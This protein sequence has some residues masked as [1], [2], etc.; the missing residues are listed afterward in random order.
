M[1]QSDASADYSQHDPIWELPPVEWNTGIPLANGDIG[2]LVWG[3]GNPLKIT[4]DKYD[5][6]ETREAKL[7]D[8]TYAQLSEWVENGERE[9]AEQ[10]MRTN[11]IY[12]DAPYPTRLPLPRLELSFDK[13]FAWKSGR[14]D[15]RHAETRIAGAVGSEALQVRA[16]VDAE[17]NVILIELK[18]TPGKTATLRARMDHLNDNARETLKKW[19]YPEPETA[20]SD[21]EGSLVQRTPSGYAYAV[22]WYREDKGDRTTYR[23]AV[24]SADDGEN[25]L[26]KCGATLQAYEQRE[27]NTHRAWWSDYWNRSGIAIPDARM[28]A[29]YAIEMYKLG[30][31]SRPG[32]WPITLQALWTQ[33]G[34]MP[35]WSGDYHLDMNVQQSYWPIYTANRLELG[36]PLYRVFSDCIPRWREQAQAFF[37]FDGIWPGCAI[38]PKGERVFGYSGVELWPGN[39]AWL[40]HHYWLHYLYSQDENF[41]RDQALP[42]MRLSFL[43]YANLLEKGDDGKLH[44]PMSYS[45]EYHE[46]N[47]EGYAKDPNGDL[48]LIRFLAGAILESNDILGAR[49]EV[50]GRAE[51]VQRDLVDYK[52]ERKRLWVSADQPLAQSHRHHSHLMALHPLGLISPETHGALIEGSLREI[53]LRGTGLWTGWAY[54]W[55]SLIASRAGYAP[56]AW[57]ML[58]EYTNAFITPNTFHVNGDYRRFG[59]SQFD[60]QPMTLEAGFGAAA[61]IQEMLLQSQGGVIR[62]FPNMPPH[63][64]DAYVYKL[65]AEGAFVIIAELKAGRTQFALILSEAG[66]PCTIRNPFGGATTLQQLDTNRN[67]VVGEPRL[68]EGD[69]LRFDTERGGAYV[70]YPEGPFP[71]I[72]FDGPVPIQHSER[73][74]HFFGIKKLPRF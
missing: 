15:L 49:D 30:C 72:G 25:P 38:G 61:A 21:W 60:Y 19:G 36:E 18:G 66:R 73:D 2:A 55:M 46:G 59:T 1:S 37:G 43:T 31:S 52:Q 8:V 7:D 44:L 40:A 20:A 13:P 26:L 27:R 10:A 24:E 45:P 68:L 47:F 33:D 22:S 53:S 41:L 5:A 17:S 4:L 42:M 71:E 6:W 64:H 12:G 9:K 67:D 3:D 11:R 56:M 57:R 54:P 35:P 63:W 74:H 69:L 16:L 65:R 58:D 70:L 48:A 29:L 39:A 62:L 34:G 51:E 50:T 14:L 32:K 28:E 23:I